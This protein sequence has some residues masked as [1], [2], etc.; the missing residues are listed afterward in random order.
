MSRIIFSEKAWDDYLYW[1]TQDRRT[2]K[3]INGLLKDIGRHPFEGEGKP[4]KLRG[5]DNLWS[6]RVNDKDRL[7]YMAEEESILV[8]QCRGHYD[9]K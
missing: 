4:E 5:M 3:K 8:V 6:R 7:I 2:L 1:Q 9:D